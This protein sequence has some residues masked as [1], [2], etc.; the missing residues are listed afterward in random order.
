MKNYTQSPLPF[1]GQKRKFL[2]HVKQVLANSSDEAIYVD[3][4]GGSGILSHTVKQLKPNA[5]VIYN[6]YDNFSKRLAS[7]S[8]TNVL[9]DKIRLIIRGLVRDKVMPESYKLKILE[10]V[11]QEEFDVGYVDYITLSSSLLFSAK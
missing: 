4:F 11:K 10:I 7:V 9:L 8:Q 1:Q 6:D 3:L 2:S 5:K